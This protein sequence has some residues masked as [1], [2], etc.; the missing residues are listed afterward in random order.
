MLARSLDQIE[1]RSNIDTGRLEECFGEGT[2][3]P[4]GVLIER[5]GTALVEQRLSHQ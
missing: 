4:S 5:Q 3:E 2:A 1:N